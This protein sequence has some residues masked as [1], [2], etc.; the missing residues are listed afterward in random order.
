MTRYSYRCNDSTC[1]LEVTNSPLIGLLRPTQQE[2]IHTR[3]YEF[4][5]L[6]VTP[7]IMDS[8]GDLTTVSFQN[9][10]NISPVF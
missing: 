5:Q 2:R 1:I 10:Y 6:P 7:W 4:S 9:Q 8:K 3:H